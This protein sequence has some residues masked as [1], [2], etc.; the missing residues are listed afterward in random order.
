MKGDVFSLLKANHNII[1]TG[2]PGTGKTFL[3]KQLACLMMFGKEDISQLSEHEKEEFKEQCGVQFHPSYD[4]TDFVEGL[5]P[6]QDDKGNV[7]FERKDGVFKE[8]CRKALE[9]IEN[10]KK[11]PQQL[12]N[13][14]TFREKYNNLI[15][16]IVSGTIKHFDLR[17]GKKMDV[18]EV[19]DKDNIVLRTHDSE[20]TYIVSLNRLSKLAKAFENTESLDRISNID[21]AL[22]EVIK[23][24]H[25]SSYWAVLKAVSPLSV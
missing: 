20:K 15:G 19:T 16:K 4:Y 3:A 17:T 10:S 21:K 18:V 7:G 24:C 22:R 2:A 11:T 14:T 12:T 6:I 5:R 1:L 25:S 8:F 13:E 9:N 23:G